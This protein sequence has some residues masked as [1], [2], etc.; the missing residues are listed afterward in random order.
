MTHAT[1]SWI[2][3]VCAVKSRKTQ[4]LEVKF[5]LYVELSWVLMFESF[6]RLL[7]LLILDIGY[8]RWPLVIVSFYSALR[9]NAF[10]NER[11]NIFR[12]S[13][14]KNSLNSCL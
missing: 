4:L 12:I 3:N 7:W 6:Q 11:F 9:K 14:R 2:E 10:K 8:Q 1:G 13:L 5:F